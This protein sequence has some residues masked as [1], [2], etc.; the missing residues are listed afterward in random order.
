M[1]IK[2]KEPKHYRVFLSRH[3]I[4]VQ[5]YDVL[6]VDEKQARKLATQAANVE[7][8]HARQDA[9]DNGWI[10]DDPVSIPRIGDTAAGVKPVA[11]VTI[12]VFKHI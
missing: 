11:K 12:N 6:A 2:K 7:R 5:F 8:P 3:Y 4:A 1:S 10:A 9:V